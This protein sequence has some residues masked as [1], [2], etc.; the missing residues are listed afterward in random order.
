MA[1]KQ[2]DTI[3][4]GGGISGLAAALYTG[5]LHLKTLLLSEKPGGTIAIAGEITNYPGIKSIKGIEL[6]DKVKEHALEY[7]VEIVETKAEQ[8]R[9][10]KTFFEITTK[11][12]KYKTKTVIFATGTAWKKLNVPGEKEFTN[13]G[14]HY[15]ALCDGPLYKGK[16]IAVVGGSDSAAKEALMLSQYAKKVYLIYRKDNIRAE[17]A[18][19]HKVMGNNKIEIVTNTNVLGIKGD[20]FVKSVILDKAYNGSKEVNVEGVF[21]NI[22]HV[23]VSDLGK[24]GGIKINE[25]GEIIVDNEGMTNIKGIYA[26]GDVTNSRLKQAITSVAQGVVAAYSAYYC[27]KNKPSET[28]CAEEY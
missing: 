9:K 21:I 15:C 27:I 23:A 28:G 13:K 10:Q 1:E 26:C 4:L 22:G 16:T 19:K 2:Y 18:N 20:K 7:G 17:G 8:L 24:D 6:Y 5:R 25:K 14:V 12:A 3:I 11:D